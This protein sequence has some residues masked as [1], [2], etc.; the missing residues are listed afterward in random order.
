M[1]ILLL[2]TYSFLQSD[3]ILPEGLR[4]Y[5]IANIGFSCW[6][7]CLVLVSA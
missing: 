1:S 7:E 6:I 3:G 4:R 2:C 5:P